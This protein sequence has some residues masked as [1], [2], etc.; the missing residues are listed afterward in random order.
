[1]NDNKI[2][3]W[4]LETQTKENIKEIATHGCINGCCN[5]L[6]YYSD[7]IAFY[8]KYH[9]EIWSLI[10]N[11][12]YECDLTAMNFLSN[13]DGNIESDTELKNIMSWVAVEI[14]CNDLAENEEVA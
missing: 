4:V 14:I 5:E 8:E 2:K 9:N 10:S 13:L 11:Y 6:I 3:S 1:M 7:T 12:A